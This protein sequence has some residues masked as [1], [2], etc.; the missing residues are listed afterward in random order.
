M[1]GMLVKRIPRNFSYVQ[2]RRTGSGVWA[3]TVSGKPPGH[4][5][6]VKVDVQYNNAAD[7]SGMNQLPNVGAAKYR[8]HVIGGR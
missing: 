3:G 5:T 2:E 1:M 4:V 6:N 7:T 8:T